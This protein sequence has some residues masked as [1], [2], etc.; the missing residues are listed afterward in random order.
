MDD[1]AD[2]D[3]MVVTPEIFVDTLFEL[4]DEDSS[5]G[6]SQEEFKVMMG[7]IRKLWKAAK[8]A[9]ESCKDDVTKDNLMVALYAAIASGDDDGS[10]TVPM[11]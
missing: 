10:D 1:G 6:I 7:E 3:D 8:Q 2:A 9:G 4:A 5:G 11:D